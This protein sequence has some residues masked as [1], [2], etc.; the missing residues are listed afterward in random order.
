MGRPAVCL[1]PARARVR[2][3]ASG[4]PRNPVLPVGAKSEPL[5]LL[6]FDPSRSQNF[7]FGYSA[8]FMIHF[9]SGVKIVDARLAVIGWRGRPG[10]PLAWIRREPLPGA[11]SEDHGEPGSR[12]RVRGVLSGDRTLCPLY[13]GH[14]RGHLQSTR[15]LFHQIGRRVQITPYLFTSGASSPPRRR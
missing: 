7:Y 10:R 5:E 15:H 6:P 9:A 3:G 14:R 12:K 8:G 13:P 1:A 11:W 4:R 2:S